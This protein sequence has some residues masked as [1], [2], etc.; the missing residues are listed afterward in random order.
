MD[1]QVLTDKCRRKLRD[2]RYEQKEFAALLELGKRDDIAMELGAGMGFISTAMAV[3]VGI[4]EIHAFEP[5]PD[6]IRYMKEVHSA[7]GVTGVTCHQEVLTEKP[8]PPLDFHIRKEFVASSLSADA[9][10]KVIRV[11]KVKR[12]AIGDALATIKPTLLVCDIEG[13]EVDLLAKADLSGLRALILELH[14]KITGNAAIRRLFAALLVQ[15]FCYS[16][17]AS[18][19]KVVGFTR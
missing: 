5:N 3:K 11:E 18:C 13:A 17:E 10:G 16:T 14:P 7:N 15:G 1:R 19:G 4:S 2:G 9:G 12:R 8:G 6:M